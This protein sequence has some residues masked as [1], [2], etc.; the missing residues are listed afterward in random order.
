MRLASSQTL[1]F[2]FKLHIE[3]RL[4]FTNKKRRFEHKNMNMF[5]EMK[6][7]DPFNME[8]NQQNFISLH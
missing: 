1:E 7:C 4:G 2:S 8:K 5:R 6:V 3:R